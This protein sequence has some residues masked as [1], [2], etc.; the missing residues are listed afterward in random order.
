MSLKEVLWAT[1]VVEL[2]SA[3]GPMMCAGC[4]EGGVLMRSV[5][6]PVS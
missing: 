6:C 4:I 5:A 1:I 2:A 3:G